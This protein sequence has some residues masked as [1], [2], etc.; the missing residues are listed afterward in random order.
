MAKEKDV[1]LNGF[2]RDM[3]QIGLYKRSQ[4]RI[5]RQLT[6]AA[7]AIVVVLSAWRIGTY[8]DTPL[9][10]FGIPSIIGAVGLWLSFRLVNMPRFA[11]FLIAV[12]AEMSKVSWPT[13]KE[14][15]QGSAVVIVTIVVLASVLVVFRFRLAV[16]AARLGRGH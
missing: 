10:H 5:T 8:G 2:W 16:V 12:E 7:L 13:R 11:D 4:G 6:F 14:L 9:T 15:F 1:S 3:F